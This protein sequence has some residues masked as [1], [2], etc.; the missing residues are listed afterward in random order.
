MYT[1]VYKSDFRAKWIS[2]SDS[3]LSRFDREKTPEFPCARFIWGWY[4]RIHFRRIFSVD[5]ELSR[6]FIHI[7]CDNI[8]DLY[9]NGF[10]VSFEKCDSGAVDITDL[11][12]QGENVLAIR[13]YQTATHD[14]FSSALTGGIRLSYKNGREEDILTDESFEFLRLV[15]FWVTEEP[16]G[17]QT[18]KSSRSYSPRV[19]TDIHPI[20]ARRSAYFASDFEISSAVR[21]ATLYGSALGCYEPYLNG[22]RVD[23]AMFM[24]SSTEKVKEYQSFDVT[25]L[26]KNG[27]NTLGAITGNGWY[28][29]SSWGSLGANKPAIMLCLEIEYENGEKQY[30]GTDESWKNYPTPLKEND[31]QF[32]ERYDARNEIDG[33]CTP[34]CDRS[35]WT[36]A[37]EIP[38]PYATLTEQNYP[39]VRPVKEHSVSYMGQTP[40]G[41]YMYDCGMNIAGV[42]KITLHNSR[43]GQRIFINCCERLKDDGITPELGAYGAVYY[44]QDSLAD[45]KAP[46]NRRNLNVYIA[47]GKETE[48]YCPR[49]TYTGFRYIYISGTDERPSE[50]DIKGVEIHNDLTPLGDFSSSDESLTRLWRAVSQT[51][52]NNCYNGPTDCPTREK[53]FWNGDSQIFINAACWIDDVSSLMARWTDAGRKMHEGP[54]GWEDEEYVIP[55]AL[56]KFY[57]DKEILKVK[58]PVMLRL[59]E[60]REEFDGMLLPEN[61]ISPYCDWL[62]PTGANLS[63]VFFSGCWWLRMLDG[64]AKIAD[65]LGDTEKRDEL[66]L[67]F[68]RGREEFN[69]RHFDYNACE[70][71]EK[72][73]SA[74]VL[75]LAFGIAPEE[76]REKIAQNLIRYIE[77][78]GRALTTGFI[79][80]RY[81]MNVLADTGNIDTAVMLLQREEFPSWNY[82]FSTG[83]TNMTESWNGMKDEDKSL[84]M[85]HFSLGAIVAW[86]FEY[87]GG[88]R[89]E[90]CSAGFSHVVLKPHFSPKIG[91]CRV[92]YRSPAGLITS[93]WHYED[94]KPVWSYT[95]PDGVTVEV[96][97]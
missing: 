87:L 12:T 73:Q 63:K 6:A 40:D 82:I 17:W 66:R 61:P 60:K 51:W 34:D 13:A 68:M 54:Y 67:R 7:K 52:R 21:R 1:K 65:I 43:K 31:L 16:D 19:V 92:S 30:I 25:H 5:G 69:R 18:D 20:A 91:D 83:A 62:N 23:E 53:N 84:S 76:Y 59:I 64:I 32:G 35:E 96:I 89:V 27:K 11:L 46:Y 26:V 37:Q 41:E 14:S 8:A 10:C 9:I 15:D 38:T 39:P 56:Y 48:T 47:R 33:W 94:G 88:I 42:V 49:F 2:A 74:L 72:I 55:Y 45:G 58:Y 50:N 85:S 80:T 29:C 24:P 90:D 86:L 57:G 79:A 28:N 78:D 70:Y 97:E 3:L 44:Q 95:V 36:N 93:E 4:T 81:L 71:D 77:R 22:E 75:P